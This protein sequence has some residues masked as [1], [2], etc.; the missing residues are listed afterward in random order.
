MDENLSF[1][2]ILSK[3]EENPSE[4]PRAPAGFIYFEGL[5][6]KITVWDEKL[7]DTIIEKGKYKVFYTHKK[8]ESNGRVYDNYLLGDLIDKSISVDP[9]KVTVTKE[10]ITQMK[11]NGFPTENLKEGDGK[12]I[13]DLIGI[14]VK[15]DES[16]SEI[17]MPKKALE[18]LIKL[19]SLAGSNKLAI[20]N[21]DYEDEDLEGFD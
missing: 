11:D 17:R 3:K 5:D 6:H 2:G 7:F 8:N 10:Q 12:V 1:E 9:E 14:P 4:N 19:N 20:M 16:V 13:W 15:E 18:Y 21:D